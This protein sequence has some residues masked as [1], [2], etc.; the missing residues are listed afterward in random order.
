M[1]ELI[2]ALGLFTLFISY[3]E[4]FYESFSSINTTNDFA[5]NVENFW[6]IWLDLILE[7]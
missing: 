3:F 1:S 4:N 5:K 6:I 2:A 7:A